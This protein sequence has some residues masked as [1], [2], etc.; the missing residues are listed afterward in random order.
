MGS[1]A[2]PKPDRLAEKLLEIRNAL[3][4]SQN[5]MLRHLELAEELFRSS[6]S[7]YEL[8]TREP[9]LPVLIK[10]ARAAGVCVDV[11]IDDAV[12]LPERIPSNPKHLDYA[13]LTTSQ[14]RSIRR[15]ANKE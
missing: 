11:L 5:E 4:F 10:Y 14:K 3:G 12:D 9:P 1:S 6:I 15:R 2:R 13:N 7:K 8:G